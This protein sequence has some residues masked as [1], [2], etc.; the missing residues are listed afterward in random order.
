M[1]QVLVPAVALGLLILV[2]RHR[3]VSVREQL[4]LHWPGF[5]PMLAWMAAF[6]VLAVI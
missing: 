4:A 6:L 1:V 5:F 2:L 3:G